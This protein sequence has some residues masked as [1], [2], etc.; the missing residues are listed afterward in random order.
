[1]Q[2]RLVDTRMP[3]LGLR[4]GHSQ[5]RRQTNKGNGVVGSETGRKNPELRSQDEAEAYS[6]WAV[7]TAQ[8]PWQIIM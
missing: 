1:M 8:L 7:G 5:G 6:A 4:E 2:Q 3:D